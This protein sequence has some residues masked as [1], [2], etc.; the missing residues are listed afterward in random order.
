[1]KS[2]ALR[3]KDLAVLRGM[4]RRFP[5]VREVRVFGSRA[6]GHAG[7]ASDLD[8]A[9]FAPDASAVEWAELCDALEN[10][11]LIY[12]LNVVRPEQT[13]N[14]RLKAKIA[15]EGVVVYPEDGSAA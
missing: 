14:P 12:E 15:Q 2:L 8:L 3:E 9:I 6:A 4:F 11:S 1:M 10:A 13:A 5:T 7:R